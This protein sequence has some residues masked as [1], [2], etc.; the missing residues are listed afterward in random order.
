VLEVRNLITR[1]GTH[2]VH[3][4]ISLRIDRGQIV[5]LFGPSGAGKSTLINFIFYGN[6]NSSG[7]LL[8]E[9]KTWNRE[10]ISKKIGVAPQH[11]GLLSDYTVLHN[12]AMPLKYVLGYSTSLAYEIASARLQEFGLGNRS[13]AQYPDSLSGGMLR[14]ASIVR[15]MIL[16]QDLL[17]LDEPLSGLDLES[18]RNVSSIISN[19]S[20]SVLCVTHEYIKADLYL[21]LYEG[22]LICGNYKQIREDPV[23]RRFVP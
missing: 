3:D 17:I 8:W 11:G 21:V 22:G 4:S 14:R 5:A 1:F 23:G 19:L 10:D 16:E 18:S 9:G 6:P 7:E 2:L 12:V 20:C 13:Y 15:A